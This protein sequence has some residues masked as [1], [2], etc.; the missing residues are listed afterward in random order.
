MDESFFD[1]EQRKIQKLLNQAKKRE[2]AQKYGARFSENFAIPPEIESQWLD[3]IEEYERQF[4]D[5]RQVT[6]R[7]FLG[8]PIFKP[9]EEIQ[10]K[11]VESEL[12][13]ALEFLSLNSIEVDCL[14][15]VTSEDLYRFVT[16][17]LM[18][19]EMDDIRV[20]G[21]TCHFTYEEFHP[22]DKYDAKTSAEDFLLNLFEREEDF[23]KVSFAKDE[24]CDSSGKQITQEQIWN[25]I[26]AFYGRYA[27][28]TSRAFDCTD[29]TLAGEY[30]TVRFKGEWTGLRSG[31]MESV[32]YKGGFD[33][34][35]KRSPYGSY[36]IIQ[37]C[38][39]GFD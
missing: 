25:I 30:A 9:F 12:D 13:T 17:E 22:N 7:E 29:C 18:D 8:G 5:A 38:L 10:P 23:L 26:H 37:A 31:S 24:L 1:E 39:P 2:L 14:A 11:H 3:N 21:F 20:G 27:L 16:T 4:K 19:H 34:R 6:V 15:E 33:F 35:L 28:F 36:D 32:T